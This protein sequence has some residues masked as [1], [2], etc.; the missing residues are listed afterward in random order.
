MDERVVLLLSTP[1]YSIG[2]GV[3]YIVSR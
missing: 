2:V 3:F 1:L